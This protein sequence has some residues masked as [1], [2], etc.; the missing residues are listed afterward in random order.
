MIVKTITEIVTSNTSQE[1]NG[2]WIPA[3]DLSYTI[4]SF[5]ERIVEAWLVFT[6]K[7]ECVKWE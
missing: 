2:K 4:R 5:R 1:T 6:G 7:C 3:R